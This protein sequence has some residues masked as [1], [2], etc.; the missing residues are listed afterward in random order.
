[1]RHVAHP[2]QTREASKFTFTELRVRD[3]MCTVSES[4]ALTPR[5]ESVA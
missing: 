5:H 1:M 2:D 4:V 3:D